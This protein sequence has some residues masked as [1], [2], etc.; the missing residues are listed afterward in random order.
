M[1]VARAHPK[2]SAVAS[3]AFHRAARE[4][5]FDLVGALEE[6]EPERRSAAVERKNAGRAHALS[7]TYAV[8]VRAEIGWRSQEGQKSKSPELNL[9]VAGLVPGLP[10]D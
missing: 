10:A 7:E 1:V 3:D 9:Q 2:F 4:R 5:I 6:G 8:R